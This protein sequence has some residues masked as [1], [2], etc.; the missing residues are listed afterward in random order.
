MP[1]TLS[2]DPAY[3]GLECAPY[4]QARASSPMA[5]VFDNGLPTPPVAW[6]SGGV[7]SALPTTRYTARL[8]GLPMT[9]AVDN[10]ALT[11]DGATASLDDIVASTDRGLLLTCLWYIREVDPQT[12]LLTGLTRDGVYVVENG[13][14]TGA[15]TN[16]RFN[17]SPVDLLS[18]IRT[19]GATQVCLGREFG[20]FFER[21]AAPPVRIEGFNMSTVSEAS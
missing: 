5:S 3:A 18:R 20:E 6:I 8:T 4:V 16:F 2:S 9:P 21:T 11:V 1:A 10:F 7:L 13:E 15:T 17:E 12:L 19:A 14:V